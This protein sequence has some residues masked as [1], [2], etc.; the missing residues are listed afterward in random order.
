MKP[1]TYEEILADYRSREMTFEAFSAYCDRNEHFEKWLRRKLN[2]EVRRLNIRAAVSKFSRSFEASIERE[3]V[4][5]LSLLT[6]DS[7]D[8]K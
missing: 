5:N 4:K 8:K 7:D 3:A 6:D 2:D 1:K